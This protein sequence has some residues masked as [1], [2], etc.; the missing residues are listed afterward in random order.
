MKVLKFGGTSVKNAENI[1][2]VIAIVKE[3]LQADTV[4][5]V[6][7]AFG[8]VTN[9]LIEAGEKAAKGDCTYTAL[10]TEIEV[11]HTE[12]I[13]TLIQS[14]KQD[15]VLNEVKA[16]IKSLTD[17][18]HGIFLIRE[19]SPRSYDMVA[20]F[21][22]RLSAYI[23]SEAF[24]EQG[25]R[26]AYLDA[27]D[28][29]KTD[30]NFGA[31]KVQFEITNKK[32]KEKVGDG[33]ILYIATGFI[34][35]TADNE[36]AT[37]GRGGSDYSGA[38]FAAALDASILEI[39]TDVDGMMTADPRKVKRAYPVKNLTYSEAMELSHFGAKVLEPR[40]VIPAMGKNIP[41]H[42]K[43]TFNPQ[44][45]GTLITADNR[46]FTQKVQ[47]ISSIDE[48]SLI[49]VQGSGMIGEVGI[50]M[51]LFQAIANNK[52]NVILITQ[53][54]SEHSIT[55]AVLPKDAQKAKELLE[56][57]FKIEL[58]V[59]LIDAILVEKNLAVIAIVGENMKKIPG[60]SG[61][62]FNTLGKNGINVSAIAQGASELNISIVISAADRNKALNALHETF[63][64]SDLRTLNVFVVG[65]GTIGN[66]LLNQIKAQRD[67]LIEK[68]NIDVR[69]VGIS[70]IDG[71]LIDDEGI[72]L[73]NW[74][75][76]LKAKAQKPDLNSYIEKIKELNLR[77]SVFV[78][79]TASYDVAAKY[80]ELLAVA[81][82]IVTPNKIAN[83]SE[84]TKYKSIHKTATQS[85]ARFLYETNV[86]AGLPVISTLKD[87]INSGDQ[88]LKIEAILSGSLNFIF[89]NI[90]T[91]NDFATTVKKA[92]ELGF[93]EP[94]PKID[95]SGMDVARKILILSREIGL[96]FNLEDIQ[97][98]NCLSQDSQKTNTVDE[99]W[100]TLES[101]DN[102]EYAQK[103]AQAESNGKRLKYIACYENGKARTEI[104]ALD[105]THPFYNVTGSDNIISFTT[106]RYKK[107]PLIV[108]GPGAGA[109]VTAA[110]I[111]A[112]I[113]RIVNY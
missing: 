72:D 113:I 16:S 11:R 40:T 18:L 98:E 5:T 80:E 95:L 4:L 66:E 39:W 3:K 17:L 96:P 110:G 46:D 103:I 13:K 30:N 109:E 37:I 86:G 48:V 22:E 82:S 107:Q 55:F 74:E 42:I 44:S 1:S 59:A 62:L 27:R 25:I 78:D 60:V 87:L 28:V 45:D 21:G 97:V 6:V 104:R 54:S 32:I 49:T 19:F 36:T 68:N 61:K 33:S 8:G 57:E 20:S 69:V 75:K 51:R 64:L 84:F 85:G 50:S 91:T 23:I 58:Q 14:S 63:F 79:N 102:K 101:S 12:A 7:S 26:A 2:K 76:E 73:S 53:G 31:A 108:I 67:I 83:A 52:I 34:G 88:I 65:T 92:R 77:N 41:V 71:F 111:F 29:V 112:D 56:E 43:N 81:V 35:S 70:N 89:S 99:L 47:G 94:D 10:I 100:K 105:N 106:A 15:Q 93:T 90:S 9:L 38:I 24:V